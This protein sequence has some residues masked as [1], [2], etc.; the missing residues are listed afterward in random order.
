MKIEWRRQMTGKYACSRFTET[1]ENDN[2]DENEKELEMRLNR[3][4]R[5]G[6]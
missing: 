2:D 3:Y 1:A 4:A 6:W 5:W